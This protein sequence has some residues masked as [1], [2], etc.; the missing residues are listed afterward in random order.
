MNK[1]ALNVNEK[2]SELDNLLLRQRVKVIP[3]NQGALAAR[4]INSIARSEPIVAIENFR[5][6]CQ[7]YQPGDEVTDL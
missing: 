3:K 4:V 6:F 5:A 7:E 1:K 2:L